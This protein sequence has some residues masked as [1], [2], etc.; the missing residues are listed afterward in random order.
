MVRSFSALLN[1]RNE[2]QIP[3][4]RNHTEMVKFSSEADKDYRTVVKCVSD[5][6]KEIIKLRGTS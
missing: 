4:A 1:L 6:V 3:V 5:C 2:S